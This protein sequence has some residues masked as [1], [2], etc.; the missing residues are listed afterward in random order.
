MDGGMKR[1]IERRE[2][3]SVERM[4]EASNQFH[5]RE[6]RAGRGLW[7]AVTLLSLSVSD[8]P[9]PQ[10]PID[11]QC[12]RSGVWLDRPGTHSKTPS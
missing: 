7:P 4:I 8:S 5:H 2:G 11:R 6:Q 3:G 12:L 9:L 1:D 10:Q